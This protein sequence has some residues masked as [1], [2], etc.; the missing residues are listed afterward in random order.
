MRLGH[1]KAGAEQRDPLPAVGDEPIR[2]RI[3]D[4]E[5]RNADLGRNRVIDLVAGVG[6]DDHAFGAAA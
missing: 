2:G 3:A 4:V 1:R 5:H 6:G